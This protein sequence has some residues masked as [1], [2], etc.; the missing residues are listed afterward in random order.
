LQEE[1]ELAF[2]ELTGMRDFVRDFADGKMS[3]KEF[4][5]G[6]Q[7]SGDVDVEEAMELAIAGLMG[8]FVEMLNG[9]SGARRR[10]AATKGKSGSRRGGA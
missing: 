8:E 6:P 7:T 10:N 1:A 5:G 9:A 2:E 3:L 4:L